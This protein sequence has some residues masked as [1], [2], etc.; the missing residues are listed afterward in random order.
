MGCNCTRDRGEGF[1]EDVFN[2]F[3]MRE[4]EIGVIEQACFKY[5]SVVLEKIDGSTTNGES[6][7]ILET[8]SNTPV[9][10]RMMDHNNH[11]C[12]MVRYDFN[13][14]KNIYLLETRSVENDNLPIHDYLLEKM[15]DHDMHSML[16]NM[17]P[18]TKDNFSEKMTFFFRCFRKMYKER[19]LKHFK[20]MLT[21]YLNY[22]LIEKQKFLCSYKDSA[23]EEIKEK[24]NSITCKCNQESIIQLVRDITEPFEGNQ[25]KDLEFDT[26]KR[27]LQEKYFFLFDFSFLRAKMI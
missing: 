17:L 10:K 26:V 3:K 11:S 15:Y 14:I 21:E 12:K 9:N 20:E 27:M 8:E 2:S 16:L 5:C 25:F 24:I 18:H 4:Y 1:I 19:K 23:N 7:E 13:R 6:S 22:N